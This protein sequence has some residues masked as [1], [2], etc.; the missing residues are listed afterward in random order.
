MIVLGLNDLMTLLSTCEV[1]FGLILRV[2]GYCF[3][4]AY[5]ICF[6]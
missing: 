1:G 3:R 4:L 2:V 5:F 6:I